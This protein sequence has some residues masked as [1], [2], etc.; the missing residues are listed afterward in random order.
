[1]TRC[2][3]LAFVERPDDLSPSLSADYRREAAGRGAA[4]RRR[5]TPCSRRNRPASARGMGEMGGQMGMHGG[6]Q[7][8]QLYPSLMAAPP[9]DPAAREAAQREAH[10][11]M[12]SGLP[13]HPR[14]S[15]TSHARA[16]G[17]R[18]AGHARGC[19]P[20]LRGAEPVPQW[21]VHPSRVNRRAYACAGRARL[22]PRSAR[23]LPVATVMPMAT[24]AGGVLWGLSWFH[25]T[26][27]AF[28][29]AFVV[30]TLLIQYTRMRQDRRFGSSPRDRGDGG[31]NGSGGGSRRRAF[32]PKAGRTVSPRRGR[33][34]PASSCGRRS[35][36][37]HCSHAA[38]LLR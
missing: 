4:A 14:R 15:R 20:A 12:T 7:Q 11:R 9:A 35:A 34:P 23:A 32:R 16:T 21:R 17:R 5:L 22:V 36:A 2:E 26:T 29:A 38:H 3:L 18:C 28:L 27:M 37:G 10:R 31:C 1:M 19:R 33:P 6:G 8:Q 24:E 13:L 25:L 30:G